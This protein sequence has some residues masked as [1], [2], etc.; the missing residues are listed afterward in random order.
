ML[1]M[2]ASFS[3]SPISGFLTTTLEKETNFLKSVFQQIVGRHTL[4]YINKYLFPIARVP[5]ME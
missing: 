5:I 1:N 4:A 3:G 2:E